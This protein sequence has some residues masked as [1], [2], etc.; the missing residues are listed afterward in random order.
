V[1]KLTLGTGSTASRAGI[2]A[3]AWVRSPAIPRCCVCASLSPKICD[4]FYDV[5]FRSGYSYPSSFE[6]LEPT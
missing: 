1:G 5:W 2:V 6:R 4:C 3:F